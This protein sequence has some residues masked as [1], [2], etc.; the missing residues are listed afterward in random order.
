[1]SDL[2]SRIEPKNYADHD[3]GTQDSKLRKSMRRSQ[4]NQ[5]TQHSRR[6]NHGHSDGQLT[7]D[8]LNFDNCKIEPRE[9]PAPTYT[10]G[11][12]SDKVNLIWAA[13]ASPFDLKRKRMQQQNYFK[14]DPLRHTKNKLDKLS[15][16]SVNP[17]TG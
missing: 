1:M 3:I 17:Y 12:R 8:I 9:R 2:Q 16:L 4:S 14:V 10:M 15:R 6:S 13:P 5:N 7:Q 11:L